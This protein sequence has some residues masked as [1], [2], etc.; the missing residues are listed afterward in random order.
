MNNHKT[1]PQPK[2][3][4]TITKEQGVPGLRDAHH[5]ACAAV[6]C[7][8]VVYPGES[9]IVSL[10]SAK[11]CSI[12]ERNAIVDPFLPAPVYPNETFWALIVPT[13]VSGLTHIFI[14]EGE[15]EL[16]PK[17]YPQ[18]ETNSHLDDAYIGHKKNNGIRDR[19]VDDDNNYQYEYD[20]CR[21][22]S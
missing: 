13:K 19:Q 9:L 7:E 5:V 10:S 22:C 2:L 6:T 14:V 21:D 18:S 3:G 11:K 12:N 20:E 17:L 4:V 16:P 8:S 1:I 15:N